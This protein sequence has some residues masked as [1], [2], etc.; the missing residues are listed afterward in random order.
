MFGFIKKI[1]K[2][3]SESVTPLDL[4]IFENQNPQRFFFESKLILF[5][6]EFIINYSLIPSELRAELSENLKYIHVNE[7][8]MYQK[9]ICP[10]PRPYRDIAVL[11]RKVKY[12]DLEIAIC[13]RVEFIAKEHDAIY[14]QKDPTFIR[15]S[16]TTSAINVIDRLPKAIAL[17]EKAMKDNIKS[18]NQSARKKR[19]PAQKRASKSPTLDEQCVEIGIEIVEMTIPCEGRKYALPNGQDTTKV[20]E[21]VLAYLN[22]NGYSCG[23][24]YELHPIMQ[25]IQGCCLEYLQKKCS[26]MYMEDYRARA[27]SVQVEMY[28]LEENRVLELV[29]GKNASQLLTAWENVYYLSSALKEWFPRMNREGIKAVVKAMPEGVLGEII[30]RIFKA[31]NVASVGWPDIFTVKD[32]KIRLFEVKVKDKLLD[33]QLYTIQNLAKPMGFDVSVIRVMKGESFHMNFD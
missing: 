30:E 20:E 21:A 28:R 11:A 6:D 26:G 7:Q 32:G 2:S 25:I 5:D 12:Y 14:A 15:F 16:Q 17:R 1:F 8:I 9:G 29:S 33:T 10:P 27:F 24:F 31:P 3:K 23:T 22:N 19:E 18:Y 4:T 13:Q